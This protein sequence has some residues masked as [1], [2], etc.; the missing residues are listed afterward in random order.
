MGSGSMSTSDA[1]EIY[2]KLQS[3]DRVEVTHEV[4]V[5]FQS[6]A[7]SAVGTLVRKER[8]RHGLHHQRS[9]DEPAMSDVMILRRADGELTT[10]A[11]DEFTKLRCLDA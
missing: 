8:R 1:L 6:W 3:G 2:R 9:P 10:I 7:T 11:L 4:K 5:G